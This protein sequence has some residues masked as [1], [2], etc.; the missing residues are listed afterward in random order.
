MQPD[1]VDIDEASGGWMPPL[2]LPRVVAVVEGRG[3]QRRRGGSQ[4]RAKAG[5]QAAADPWRTRFVMARACLG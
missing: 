4:R 3:R 2:D 5:R 1:T